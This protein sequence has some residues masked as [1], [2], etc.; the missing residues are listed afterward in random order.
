MVRRI[1]QPPVNPALRADE[2]HGFG[3]GLA[4]AV[5]GIAL[6]TWG[7]RRST[8]VEAFAGSHQADPDAA[9]AYASE[10]QLMKSY[11]SSG[12]QFP[13]QIAPPPPPK[14]DDPAA[15]RRWRDQ[16]ASAKPPSWKVRV[17]L[18]AKAACPT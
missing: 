6:V 11:S 2:R 14:T 15:L 16:V 17:D 13:D 18:E 12:L 10:P 3:L 7:V 1:P 8:A 9:P 5:V 4:L